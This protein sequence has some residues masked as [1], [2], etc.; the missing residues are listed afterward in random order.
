MHITTNNKNKPKK[1]TTADKDNIDHP[2]ARDGCQPRRQHDT[3]RDVM[4]V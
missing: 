2:T 3:R 1:T 4:H